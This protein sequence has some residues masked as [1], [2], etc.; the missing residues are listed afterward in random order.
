MNHSTF[1]WQILKPHRKRMIAA[2]LCLMIVT[3][4]GIAPP[5]ILAI[6][7]DHVIGLGQ[8]H[9][10]PILMLMMLAVPW[11]DGI[12][13]IAGNHLVSLLG[14]RLAMD[15]RLELYRKV[16]K[17]SCSYLNN[18]TT[19]ALMERL[20]GDVDQVQNLMT[21]QVLNLLAQ[22]VC[23]VAA[24]VIISVL[25][26][27]LAVMIF[28]AIAL[29]VANY[30]WFVRR[31]RCVQKRY[32]RKMDL[33]SGHAQE[34]L[35]GSIIVK[36]YGNERIESRR[37]A[38]S[39]FFAERVFHRFRLYN[40]FYG[41]T[42]SAIAWSTYLMVL[43]TGTWL[44]IHGEMTYGHVLAVTAYTWWLLNPAIQLAELSNQIQQVKVAMDRIFALMNADADP[45][46][47]R[48]LRPSELRGEIVFKNV[49]FAYEADNPVLRH[50]NLDVRPG[51]TVAFVGHTGCGK[52][53]IVN[54]LYRFY[55]AKSGQILVDGHDISSLET[56]WYRRRLAMVPQDPIVFD[57]TIAAN[58]AYGRSRADDQQIERALRTVELGDLIYRAPT[59]IHTPLGERGMKLS[60]GEKQR[61]CIARAILA[62]PA[63]LILD[64]ATSSL[65]S[66]SESLIQ[67]ALK[68]VMVN[69]TCF[70][71]AHRLSTI[72]NAD[73]IVVMD[74]GRIIELGNHNQLMRKQD[75]HYRHLFVTQMAHQTI[76]EVAS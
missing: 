48:G 25:S 28:V 42:S 47:Q 50:V 27:K 44:A 53:T 11:L 10:L 52:S 13:R 23:A 66:Q 43:L 63:V 17:L 41:L 56:R 60:V 40:I 3:L 46:E 39:N 4:V 72:V 18:T 70:V 49:C 1:I 55:E 8:Y 34:R 5:M 36:A 31:I 58:V 14:Q 6:L 2:M 73:Q 16:H 21:Q 54:L 76:K 75:G 51:Q 22:L 19:G 69:R 32:R 65:D 24:L 35:A 12:F 37:F 38:R 59:G 67:L 45:V 7:V 61:L 68:R 62:D 26:V 57:T 9:W 74:Q 30:K 20:R 15:V 33:L 64:E 71:V 29:Y